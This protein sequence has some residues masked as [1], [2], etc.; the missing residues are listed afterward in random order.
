M[1]VRCAEFKYEMELGQRMICLHQRENELLRR[2][3]KNTQDGY[4]ESSKK[5]K[6]VRYKRCVDLLCGNTMI[7]KIG[8]DM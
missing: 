2:K 5:V 7:V 1:A 6:E 3:L 8:H 4:S